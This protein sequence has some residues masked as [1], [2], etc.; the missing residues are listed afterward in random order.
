M[1]E[2]WGIVMDEDAVWFRIHIFWDFNWTNQGPGK[3]FLESSWFLF[4]D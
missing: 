2:E 4:M 3:I 1:K